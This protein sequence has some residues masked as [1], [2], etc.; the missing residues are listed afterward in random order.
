[1]KNINILE[2]KKNIPQLKSLYGSYHLVLL[3]HFEQK[4]ADSFGL[5]SVP[6]VLLAKESRT[7][8]Q[9]KSKLCKFELAV[10]MKLLNFTKIKFQYTKNVS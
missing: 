6:S 1:M 2:R 8:K 5:Y 10:T 3:I 4:D 9:C 7:L